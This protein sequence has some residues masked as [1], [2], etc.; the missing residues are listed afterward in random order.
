MLER[1]AYRT[2]IRKCDVTSTTASLFARP[3]KFAAYV[4]VSKGIEASGSRAPWDEVSNH[5]A[6]TVQFDSG[7]RVSR[8][9]PL[10]RQRGDNQARRPDPPIR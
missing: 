6:L 1:A 9:L 2:L 8:G 7:E 10:H 5:A 3:A 4:F